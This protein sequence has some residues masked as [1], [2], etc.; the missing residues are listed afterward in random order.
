MIRS[1]E[2]ADIPHLLEMGQAFHAES[3]WGKFAAFDAESWQATL[4]LFL[5]QPNWRVLV[6]DE[7]G[8][9]GFIC[10]SVMPLYFNYAESVAHELLW[11]V[12]P[13]FR[14]GAGGELLAAFHRGASLGLQTVSETTPR[15]E[16]V[17]R[18]LQMQ[19]WRPVE[20]IF[21]KKL[22]TCA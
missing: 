21:M 9:Q 19:G 18:L 6:W 10:G 5:E 16:A 1:A 3:G 7:D 8:P 2:L 15:H 22:N 12:R 20:R 17:A 4:L 14:R 11:W 13:A